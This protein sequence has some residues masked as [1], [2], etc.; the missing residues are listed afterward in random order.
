[1]KRK[2]VNSDKKGFDYPVKVI[3]EQG[4]FCPYCGEWVSQETVICLCGYSFAPVW[5]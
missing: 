1:M 5:F 3:G 4:K 2:R